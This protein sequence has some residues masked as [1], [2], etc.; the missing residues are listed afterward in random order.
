MADKLDRL[1]GRFSQY[2]LI[3]ASQCNTFG[4]SNCKKLREKG[5]NSDAKR[6]NGTKVP[7][8]C[9]RL[10]CKYFP[11]CPKNKTRATCEAVELM[12]APYNPVAIANNFLEQFGSQD[13]I[14]HMKLQKLVYCSY[15]WWLAAKGMNAPRLTTDGPQIWKHGPVFEDVYH[16]FKV[17][18]RQGISETKSSNPFT[19]PENVDHD[20]TETRGLI[21][22][23]FERYGHLSSFDLSDMT[24]KPGTPWHRVAEENNFRVPFNTPIPDQY[25]YEE[26][27]AL[28]NGSKASADKLVGN[29]E[30]R[31][32][33]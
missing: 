11:E 12:P 5:E 1:L 27:T 6:T 23:I 20:D 26:F 13:G 19:E 21:G 4:T 10:C 29:D 17:F 14:E 30:H 32:S 16:V 7:C 28:M 24:H 25:I 31:H 8:G 15:G 9:S 3:V 33:A 18:G 2:H 22:W